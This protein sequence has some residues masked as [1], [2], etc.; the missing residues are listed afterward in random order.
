MGRYARIAVAVLALLLLVVGSALA[1]RSPVADEH[2]SPVAASQEPSPGAASDKSDK[3]DKKGGDEAE[4]AAD[5]TPPSQA[6]LDRL[7]GLLKTAG[8][9]ATDEQLTALIAKYGIGGAMRVLAWAH[10]GDTSQ[11]TALRDQG[12]GWGEIARQLNEA[13]S[14]ANFRPGIGWIMSGGHG[15][16]NAD[17]AKDAAKSKAKPKADDTASAPE[18]T[19]QP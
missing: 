5:T 11:V 14:S 9:T 7:I 16:G 8:V 3:S 1:N 4:D 2:R 6:Q 15:G 17:A 18:Q 12:L 19:D 10:D 13:D